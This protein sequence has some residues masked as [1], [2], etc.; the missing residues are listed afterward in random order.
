[1][2]G[3]HD[4]PSVGTRPVLTGRNRQIGGN[5]SPVRALTVFETPSSLAQLIRRIDNG[6]AISES[7]QRQLGAFAV[8]G[9]RRQVTVEDPVAAPAE[10]ERGGAKGEP[11]RMRRR[12]G[13]G[14]G[15]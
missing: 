12:P 9:S 8:L 13:A 2:Y 10:P 11:R 3:L 4:V 15:R 1:M 6:T 7:L 14:A 5:S